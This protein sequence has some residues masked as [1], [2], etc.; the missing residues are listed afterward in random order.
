M[1][2]ALTTKYVAVINGPNLNLIG[3]REPEIY[4]HDTLDSILDDVQKVCVANGVNLIRFQSN[5]EGDLI[6]KV[7]EYGFDSDC[8]GI[9]INPG[10]L[11][12]YSYALADALRAVQVRV[13]EV[14]ISNIHSRESFRHTS[15]T[16][17]AASAMLC[18]FGGEGYRMAAENLLNK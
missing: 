2:F 9:I 14:H 11:A 4:G 3:K 12:H 13:I 10:A 15:V 1:K 7:Q 17:S 5:H 16:A 6:D 18:G 8:S